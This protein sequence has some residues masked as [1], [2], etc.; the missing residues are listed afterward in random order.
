MR[1]I[2]CLLIILFSVIGLFGCPSNTQTP[3]VNI[4]INIEDNI[5][6]WNKLSD[7]EYYNVFIDNVQTAKVYEES[8]ELKLKEGMYQIKVNAKL[9]TGFSEYSNVLS[10][11][12]DGSNYE[13]KNIE[14]TA[15]VL[16]LENNIL[17]WNKVSNAGSYDIYKNGELLINTTNLSL[18]IPSPQFL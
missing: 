10:Y 3:S 14:L 4:K 17:S 15:P 7:A 18:E 8:F 12:S 6:T 13:G 5:L 11:Y 16:K 2:L 1:K 9:S